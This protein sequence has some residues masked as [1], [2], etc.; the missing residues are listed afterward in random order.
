MFNL[1]KQNKNPVRPELVEGYKRN[2][3]KKINKIF[4][5]S[6]HNYLLNRIFLNGNPIHPSTGSGRTGFLLLNLCY[7]NR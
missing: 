1:M 6:Q 7:G 2:P 4:Q 5:N 3:S